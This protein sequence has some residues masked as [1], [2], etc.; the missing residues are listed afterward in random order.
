MAETAEVD[1]EAVLN[2][3]ENHSFVKVVSD[4]GGLAALDIDGKI[5]TWGASCSC[6]EFGL[7]S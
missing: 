4:H 6:G 1:I 3:S 7:I 5:I 2:Y